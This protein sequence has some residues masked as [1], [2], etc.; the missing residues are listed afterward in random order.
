MRHIEDFAQVLQ[1]KTIFTTLDLV[2]AYH[3]IPITEKDIPKTA[4]TTPFGMYKFRYMSFGKERDA[5]V[6]AIHR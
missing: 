3:Q 1:G 4:I 5:D 6:S 2:R